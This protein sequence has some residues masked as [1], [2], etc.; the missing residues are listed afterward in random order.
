MECIVR[1]TVTIV[2]GI[3]EALDLQED[4]EQLDNSRFPNL[5]IKPV[6]NELRKYLKSIKDTTLK[7]N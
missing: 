4:L 3:P 6:S 2:L 5:N 7:K 1:K